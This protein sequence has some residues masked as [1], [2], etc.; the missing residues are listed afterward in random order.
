MTVTEI[1]QN[2]IPV[3]RGRKPAFS[4]DNI[5]RALSEAG[6]V[7]VPR[8]PTEVMTG[9][10][11]GRG[12]KKIWRSHAAFRQAWSTMVEALESQTSQD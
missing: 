9:A 11:R 1:I 7:I 3:A 8:E 2:T 5:V 6:Y 10:A 12:K 4:A